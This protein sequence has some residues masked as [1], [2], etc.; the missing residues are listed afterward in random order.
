MTEKLKRIREDR[1]YGGRRRG[2]SNKEVR[3]EG[4]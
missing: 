1:Y 4:V 2:D 3:R